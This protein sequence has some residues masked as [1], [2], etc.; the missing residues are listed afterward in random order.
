[1]QGLESVVP[2]IECPTLS[3]N[4]GS[5][6]F[7]DDLTR[8]L[9]GLEKL[10]EVL[11]GCDLSE[12]MKYQKDAEGCIS[13]VSVS[14]P[15][16]RVV[17]RDI[18][19]ALEQGLKTLRDAISAQMVETY[20]YY[21]GMEPPPPAS[22]ARME[23]PV[24]APSPLPTP[25][26]PLHDLTPKQPEERKRLTPKCN[27]GKMSA[28]NSLGEGLSGYLYF[29]L[30]SVVHHLRATCA[31]VWVISEV[32]EA[33]RAK[34][35]FKCA[36]SYPV[37]QNQ[38]VCLS[39]VTGIASMV[40]QSHVALNMT[41]AKTS[42]L[43]T[44]ETQKAIGDAPSLLCFPLCPHE[45]SCAGVLFVT[46]KRA[47][48]GKFT[49]EDE[50]SVL[51]ASQLLSV[52]LSVYGKKAFFRPLNGANYPHLDALLGPKH[53]HKECFVPEESLDK[54]VHGIVVEAIGRKK[55]QFI[56]RTGV[57]P[58]HITGKERITAK[59]V[60]IDGQNMHDL[61]LQ[62]N[63]M[64]QMWRCSL[65]ENS[66]LNTECKWWQ[67]RVAE[68]QAKIRW[69]NRQ[70]ERAQ[71]CDDNSVIKQI[72]AEIAPE[73]RNP[74][75]RP[76]A[77]RVRSYAAVTTDFADLQTKNH[78]AMGLPT[79]DKT[80][81]TD[82]CFAD[83][84]LQRVRR[85]HRL[86]QSIFH[87]PRSPTLFT[88]MGSSARSMRGESSQRES[89]VRVDR[90]ASSLNA[91]TAMSPTLRVPVH[92]SCM[93]RPP[94]VSSEIDTAD[95]CGEVSLNINDYLSRR[96]DKDAPVSP[97]FDGMRALEGPARGG[98]QFIIPPEL[99]RQKVAF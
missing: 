29:H 11:A 67:G 6:P 93:P 39:T 43:Y 27:T 66:V 87:M 46:N 58:M 77:G 2:S 40:H 35:I 64:E 49:N 19:K 97:M 65:N 92:P 8:N 61:S 5:D 68:S 53:I 13:Y 94:V 96:D 59:A 17:V 84:P 3:Q 48:R 89:S 91:S 12:E 83:N 10:V 18:G 56:Y 80:C 24:V 60:A 69:M 54:G 42:S 47:S 36:S 1:M 57:A 14:L 82:R 79:E 45:E 30:R 71:R 99:K 28:A 98:L 21:K 73:H 34:S 72:L 51:E 62:L 90:D 85:A 25:H 38:P 81:Q 78:G 20:R 44:L 31:S 26:P 4:V 52:L 32:T 70:S 95:T 50:S 23:F 15:S 74:L 76:S 33:G 63:W 22:P 9:R 75:P 41:D 16:A 37:L 88:P 55:Q 7:S 86:S